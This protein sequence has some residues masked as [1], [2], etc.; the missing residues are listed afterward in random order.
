MNTKVKEQQARIDA[1]VTSWMAELRR[2]SSW[3]AGQIAAAT[4]K[5][6]A[7]VLMSG[8]DADYADVIPELILEDALRVVPHGWPEGIEC[9][10]LNPSSD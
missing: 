5:Q 2:G 9:E 6:Y 3:L 4:G 8:T 10:V 7:V 1:Q